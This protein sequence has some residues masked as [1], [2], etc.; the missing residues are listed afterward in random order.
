MAAR[1]ALVLSAAFLCLVLGLLSAPAVPAAVSPSH[2][3]RLADLRLDPPGVEAASAASALAGAEPRA[4]VVAGPR[5]RQSRVLAYAPPPRPPPPPGVDTVLRNSVAA[6]TDTGGRL[7]LVL[8]GGGRRLSEGDGFMGWSVASVSRTGAVLRKGGARREVS[9]FAPGPSSAG[10][11]ASDGP[12]SLP[13][14]TGRRTV[15]PAPTAPT[16]AEFFRGFKG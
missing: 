14:P 13:P 12:A 4:A 16:A 6:V 8:A 10:S 1:I 15:A 5:A 2:P 9:F 11:A 3:L 7:S